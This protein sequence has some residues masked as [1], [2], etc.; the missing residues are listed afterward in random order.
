MKIT[1]RQLKRII[2]EELDIARKRIVTDDPLGVQEAY[3]IAEFLEH[4]RGL[5]FTRA[6]FLKLREFLEK[7]EASGDVRRT[8]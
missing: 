7:V 6:G 8:R 5:V 4:T 1:K 3:D 2:L